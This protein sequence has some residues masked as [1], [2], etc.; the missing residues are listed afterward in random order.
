MA[1]FDFENLTVEQKAAI[2]E[3]LY[4]KYSDQPA[5]DDSQFVVPF[6]E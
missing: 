1:E 2:Q 3:F 4:K 5:S 6:I